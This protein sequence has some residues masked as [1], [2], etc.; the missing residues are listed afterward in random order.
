MMNLSMAANVPYT[1]SLNLVL[2][3]VRL[4]L[5]LMIFAHGYRK[6]FGGGKIDGTAKW[7]DSIGM[8]PGRLNAYMGA[9]TE[10]GVGVLLVLG[11]LT[12]LAAAGLISVMTVA[13]LTVHIRNGFFIFNKGEGVEYC[14]G[15]IVMCLVP[16]TL[17]GGKYSLDALWHVMNWSNTDNFLLTVVVGFGGA[18]LQLATFYRPAR[19]S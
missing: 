15:V 9:S 12:P 13:I 5:G 6:F 11:L 2:V 10:V 14:L 7:F 1:T 17:G 8:R 3:A 4:F 18:L 19:K 16:G